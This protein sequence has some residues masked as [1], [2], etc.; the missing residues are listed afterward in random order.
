MS[1]FTQGVRGIHMHILVSTD[2]LQ[3]LHKRSHLT[4][5]V[6]AAINSNSPAGGD[7]FLRLRYAVRRRSV[8]NS[9]RRERFDVFG[10]CVCDADDVAERGS[11]MSLRVHC[12]SPMSTTNT[13][14]RN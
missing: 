6:S 11:V 13:A 2:K 8:D 12:A 3:L 9:S 14:T 7:S 1:A 10:A 5:A 4:S